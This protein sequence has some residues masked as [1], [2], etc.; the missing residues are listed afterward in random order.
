[1]TATP[2]AEDTPPAPSQE[3]W[4]GNEEGGQGGHDLELVPDAEREANGNGT[5]S[6]NGGGDVRGV[7]QDVKEDY[8][9]DAP[10]NDSGGKAAYREKQ[11]KVLSFF[12]VSTI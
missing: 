5:A 4:N 7:D 9:S 3:K 1:M 8:R 6:A 11:P 10:A 2:M 12:S